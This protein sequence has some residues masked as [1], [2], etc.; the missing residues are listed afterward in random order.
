MKIIYL[1]LTV[2]YAALRKYNGTVINYNIQSLSCS[3]CIQY[4]NDDDLH[5]DPILETIVRTEH[6]HCKK[7]EDYPC[8][9]GYT[10]ELYNSTYTC[11]M[12]VV[13][14][15][16]NYSQVTNYLYTKYPLQSVSIIYIDKKNSSICYTNNAL[17]TTINI[18]IIVYCCCFL[19][20]LF[21]FN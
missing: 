20:M 16:S 14:K 11:A 7:Y 5:Y 17:A 2:T 13:S 21:I 3:K 4:A 10:S 12:K 6:D 18:H 15:S 19:I 1:F 8:Y 9:N